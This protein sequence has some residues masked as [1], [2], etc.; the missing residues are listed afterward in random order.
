MAQG[1]WVVR[2][3]REEGSTRGKCCTT[4][5]DVLQACPQREGRWGSESGVPGSAT[6]RPQT[7]ETPR[8]L[9]FETLLT[10]SSSSPSVSESIPL[11]SPSASLPAPSLPGSS[12][13]AILA[14]LN[15]FSS[16]KNTSAFLL[17]E[18]SHLALSSSNAGDSSTANAPRAA[19][20]P[21]TACEECEAVK[22]GYL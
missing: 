21:A 4:T 5:R 3:E 13:T 2:V 18:Q 10:I 9:R 20:W 19:S 11:L 8:A 16:F 7:E 15:S 12:T 14:F 22:S 1:S 6:A 17:L